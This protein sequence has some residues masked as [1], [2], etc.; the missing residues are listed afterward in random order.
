MVMTAKVLVEVDTRRCASSGNC[1]DVAP[2]V[3][4]QDDETG[5]VVLLEAHPAPESTADVEQAE[6]LCP[7]RA[8]QLSA[9]A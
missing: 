4:T 9:E 1:A 2:E 7:A 6:S 3:F 5:V 8:I